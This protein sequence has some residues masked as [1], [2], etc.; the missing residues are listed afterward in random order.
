M[1]CGVRQKHLASENTIT[2]WT[3]EI[4]V[5]D[6]LTRDEREFGVRRQK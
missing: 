2:A 4:I 3:H 5:A 1:F 6:F